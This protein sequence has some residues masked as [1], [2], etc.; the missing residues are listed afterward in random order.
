VVPIRLAGGSCLSEK[1]R[2]AQS[3]G[4]QCRNLPR[5]CRLCSRSVR[6]GSAP[7]ARMNSRC[8]A[9]AT[10]ASALRNEF[11]H[12][13]RDGHHRCPAGDAPVWDHRHSLALAIRRPR[14]PRVH[15]DVLPERL[16]QVREIGIRSVIRSQRGLGAR[17]DQ[18]RRLVRR[19]PRPAIAW[20][21]RR[22]P[23]VARGSQASPVR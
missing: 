9:R 5:S 1:V 7:R 20:K 10:Q 17:S 19:M 3:R 18:S 15:A 14:G 4:R 23:S 6:A 21:P 16:C 12:E 13:N 22:W 2:Q 8:R 11:G